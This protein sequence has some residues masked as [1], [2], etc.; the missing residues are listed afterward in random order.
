MPVADSTTMAHEYGTIEI[1]LHV[2]GEYAGV[3]VDV[4][5]RVLPQAMPV[6]SYPVYR[7]QG[8]LVRSGA[9]A[10]ELPMET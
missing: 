2:D 9:F 5:E 3:T 4:P 8:R 7:V 6:D 10:G 1:P